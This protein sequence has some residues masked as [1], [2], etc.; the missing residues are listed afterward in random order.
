MKNKQEKKR[1]KERKSVCVGVRM[2]ESDNR[3]HHGKSVPFVCMCNSNRY[4]YVYDEH[5]QTERELEK[6]KQNTTK[7]TREKG[8]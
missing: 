2:Y 4:R 1:K 3:K 6:T 5:R 8:N 7:T